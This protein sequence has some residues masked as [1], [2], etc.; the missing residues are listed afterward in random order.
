V[1]NGAQP[2]IDNVVSKINEE[3]ALWERAG[4]QGLRVIMPQT[5]DVH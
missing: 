3:A 1:F 2:S 4:A 5:W